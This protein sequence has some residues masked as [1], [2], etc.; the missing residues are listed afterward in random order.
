VKR[1]EA[2][3]AFGSKSTC[4]GFT[5][6]KEEAQQSTCSLYITQIHF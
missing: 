5:H 2:V 4:V 3:F 1:R 6:H